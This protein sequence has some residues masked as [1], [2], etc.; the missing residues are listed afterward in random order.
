MR[1]SKLASFAGLGV[2]T[3]GVMTQFFGCGRGNHGGTYSGYAIPVFSANSP[4]YVNVA[5]Q[6][7]A[8]YVMLNLRQDGGVVT[9]DL[10]TNGAYGRFN[11]NST[12]NGIREATLVLTSNAGMNVNSMNYNGYNN[13]NVGYMNN[14]FSANTLVV[15][16]GSFAGEL[17]SAGTNATRIT[18]TLTNRVTASNNIIGGCSALQLDVSRGNR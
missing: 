4:A 10:T 11:G 9:G 12:R 8:I 3:F 18:G 14:A 13:N 15:C 6:S 7:Q 2:L 16:N 5:N 17:N 1:F